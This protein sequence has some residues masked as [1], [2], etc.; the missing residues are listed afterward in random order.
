VSSR[1]EIKSQYDREKNFGAE[2]NMWEWIKAGGI[3][4]V[5]LGVCSVMALAII[6][7]R[8]YALRWRRVIKPE[9]TLIVDNIQS[10]T[11]LS[12]ALSLFKSHNDSFSAIINA[13]VEHITLEHNEI[14]ELTEEQ[15]R[16]EIKKL[17]KG[18]AFLET[19]AGISPL[20][21]L[22]GTVLGMIDVFNVITQ[23][24]TPKTT[25]LSHGISEALITTVAGLVI[26]IFALVFF[27]YYANK[28][29]NMVLEIEKYSSKLLNK[30]KFYKTS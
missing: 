13:A 7:E 28:A 10:S 25:Q 14:K 5:P 20:L 15:G 12:M 6:I 1:I 21:G 11:D 4:M 23:E 30:M 17:E 24:G 9:T 8:A 22:L 19:I 26:A 2:K 18:L 29:E 3:M 16:R 27:N